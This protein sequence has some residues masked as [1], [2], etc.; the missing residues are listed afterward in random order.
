MGLALKLYEQIEQAPDERARFRLIID[1]IGQLEEGWPRPGEIARGSDVRE[2]ELRLQLEIE[3]LR[4]DVTESGL[5]LQAEIEGVRKD[6]TQMELRLQKE[7]VQ[8]RNDLLKWLVPLMFAQVI[9]IATLVK[10]L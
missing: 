7:I 1:A 6:I 2:S 5:R 4:K 9:A 3:G 10:V 8:S